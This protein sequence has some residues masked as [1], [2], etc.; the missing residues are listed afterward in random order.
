MLLW[1]KKI[2][3]AAF[4]VLFIATS[5]LGLALFGFNR[6]ESVE[7]QGMKVSLRRAEQIE[8]NVFA[9]AETVNRL[10]EATAEIAVENIRLARPLTMDEMGRE[11]MSEE[12]MTRSRDKIISTLKAAGSEPNTIDRLATEVNAVVLESLKKKL[13]WQIMYSP[14][15]N[16]EIID[17]SYEIIFN[18]YNRQALL[19]Y[20]RAKNIPSDSLTPLLDRVDLFLQSGRL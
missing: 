20:L 14:G 17:H 12:Q 2:Q 10:A 9:K 13:Y 19:D 7:T 1:K 18:A 3:S 4:T 16:K 11:Q 6:L 8:S 5:T 15:A